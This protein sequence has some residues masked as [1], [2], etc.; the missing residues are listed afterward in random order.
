[1]KARGSLY[2]GIRSSHQPYGI[3]IQLFYKYRQAFDC[4]NIQEFNVSPHLIQRFLD[5]PMREASK[6]NKTSRLPLIDWFMKR[7]NICTSIIAQ[8][9]LTVNKEECGNG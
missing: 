2:K 1:M 6:Q 5:I 3:I 7:L 4:R 9:F 8:S